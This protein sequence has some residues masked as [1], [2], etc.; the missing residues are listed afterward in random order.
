MRIIDRYVVRH[1]IPSFLWCLAIFIFL[2]MIGDLFGHL[3]EIVRERVSVIT[4]GYYYITFAPFIFVLTAPFAILLATIHK[5]SN[6]NRHN[7]ITA[8]RASGINIWE[9]L[10]PILLI[11]LLTSVMVFLVNDKIV[12]RSGRISEGIKEELIEK[13]VKTEKKVI[14]NV[15]I[16][17][18]K[19][20]IIYARKFDGKNNKLTDIIIHEHDRSQNLKMKISA[21]RA[22]YRDDKWYFYDALV[23]K[24]DNQGKLTEDPQFHKIMEVDIEEKPSDFA[25]KEWRT[26][27]MSYQDLRKYVNLFKGGAKKTLNRLRVDLYHKIFFPFANFVIILVGAPF[28]MHMRR[29]GML[30]GIGIGIIISLL[31]FACY[32]ITLALGKAGILPP[33]IAAWLANVA[34]GVYGFLEIQK[35]R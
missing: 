26:E 34:F 17:A 28:A 31:Y 2:Y 18:A 13:K 8:I 6:L 10:R 4:L 21:P 12:S 14:N 33:L 24:V 25:K 11:G 29:G 15:A 16:Y 3:D 5:L 32:A 20:R 27:F 19:N 22:R 35:I 23:S 30:A 1:F 9:I 7:E